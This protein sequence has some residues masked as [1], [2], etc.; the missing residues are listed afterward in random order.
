M[1]ERNLDTQTESLEPVG[2][3]RFIDQQPEIDRLKLHNQRLMNPTQKVPQQAPTQVVVNPTPPAAVSI[4]P[5][6]QDDSHSVQVYNN[7]RF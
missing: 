2:V 4:Q 1:L 5:V 6:R 7:S 3:S